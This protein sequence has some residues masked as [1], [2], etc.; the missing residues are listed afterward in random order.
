V[1]LVTC[2]AHGGGL[3]Q[4]VAAC[5]VGQPTPETTRAAGEHALHVLEPRFPPVAARLRRAEADLLAYL[6]F[7]PEHWR[8]I[9]STDEIVKAMRGFS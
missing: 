4:A 6:S 2:D 3:R 7:P 8:S 9:S 5:F 1:R